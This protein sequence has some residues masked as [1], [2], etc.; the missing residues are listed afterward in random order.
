MPDCVKQVGCVGTPNLPTLSD[1]LNGP[2]SYTTVSYASSTERC[3]GL[4]IEPDL[5]PPIR[6]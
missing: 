6:S 4:S 5:S 3:A 2:A 1:A